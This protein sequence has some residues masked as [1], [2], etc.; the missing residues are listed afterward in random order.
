MKRSSRH[1][2][3]ACIARDR[4]RFVHNP[5]KQS[6]AQRQSATAAAGRKDRAETNAANGEHAEHELP[7]ADGCVTR[8]NIVDTENAEKR[9]QNR[10]QDVGAA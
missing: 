5:R 2:S 6:E 4:D 10:K 7:D 8:D 9:R 1:Q 3:S